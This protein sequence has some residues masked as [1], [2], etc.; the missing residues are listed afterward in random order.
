MSATIADVAKRAGVSPATVSKFLNKKAVS[1]KNC[2]RIKEAIQELNYQVNDFARSLRTN[3][4]KLI[5]LLVPSIDYTFATSLFREMEERLTEYDYGS[6]LYNYHHNAATFVEK[7]ALIRQRMVDGVIVLIS[8]E[9]NELIRQGLHELQLAKIPFVLVN[10]KVDGIEADTVL[11]DNTQA[12]YTCVSHLL[13]NGHRKICLVMAQ[14]NSYNAR[15][16]VAGLHKAYAEFDLPVDKE[17]IFC[18]DSQ[19]KWM[20]KAKETLTE[21]VQA[22]P[23]I[24]ALVLPSYRMAVVSLQVSRQLGRQIGKDIALVGF[25]CDIV[26]DAL[27]PPL[28][29][30]RLSADEIAINAIG[31]MLDGIKSNEEKAPQLIRV[32]AQ[33][34]KGKS[35]FR[36]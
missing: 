33:M 36:I 22:H 30:M 21:F 13:E 2:E 18:Y 6:V 3:T 16:R 28:T 5:G 15:E 10:G 19:E 20:V 32:P 23:E 7:I 9:T 26:N 1:E 14:S 11:A 8:G 12:I 17:L 25:D 29:Y 4:S 34:V 27:D 24:T 35:V 31:L